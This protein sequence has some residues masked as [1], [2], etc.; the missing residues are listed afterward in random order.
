MHKK[1]QSWYI[2]YVISFLIFLAGLILA[3]HF[4]PNASG[5]DYERLMLESEILSDSVMS[6][7]IPSE[8][9]ETDVSVP[10][11]IS[12]NSLDD[13]KLKSLYRLDYNRTRELLSLSGDYLI[14]IEKDGVVQNITG[15]AHFGRFPKDNEHMLHKRRI[16]PY[17]GSLMVLNLV[18][19]K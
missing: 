4:L 5:N 15:T 2:D 11:I 1:A 8:W 12:S 3:L 9:N 17:N 14:Y 16:L 10:G 18:V 6:E 13:E 7:G 19:W